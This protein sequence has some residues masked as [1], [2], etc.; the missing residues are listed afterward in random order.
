MTPSGQAEE[1]LHLEGTESCI[2]RKLAPVRAATQLL[3]HRHS[4][5]LTNKTANQASL[6][7]LTGEKGENARSPACEGTR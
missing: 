6:R 5:A 3:G 4:Q 1:F 2:Q 7:L